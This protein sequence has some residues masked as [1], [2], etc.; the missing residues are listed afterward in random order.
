MQFFFPFQIA[1]TQALEGRLRKSGVS[2]ASLFYSASFAI[3][4]HRVKNN[5]TIVRIGLGILRLNI[6]NHIY[7]AC[8]SPPFSGLR[9]CRDCLS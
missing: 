2:Y 4:Y 3:L 6:R 1:A 7:H 5:Y 9:P 8:P